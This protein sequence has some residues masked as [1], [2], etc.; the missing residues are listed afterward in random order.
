MIDPV[1]TRARRAGWSGVCTTEQGE[2]RFAFFGTCSDRCPT[3]HRAEIKAILEV[4]RRARFPLKLYT[5][6]QSAVKAWERGREYCCDSSRAAADIWREIWV[7]YDRL[8]EAMDEALPVLAFQL[9]WVKSH[10]GEEALRE[11]VMDPRVQKL[12]ALADHYAGEGSRWARELVPNEEQLDVYGT[13]SAFYRV[14]GA[15]CSEWPADYVQDRAKPEPGPA[16]GG[17]KEWSVHPSR[18]HEPWRALGGQGLCARCGRRSQVS[19]GAGLADFFRS[20]CRMGLQTEMASL[21]AASRA[22]LLA[23]REE[24][25]SSGA[26]PS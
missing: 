17:V 7:I 18:P 23:R 4:V 9:I 2:L 22:S 5:D 1:P 12:N 26:A 21:T 8:L 13:A 20:P 14:M 25:T 10:T 11:G 24:M 15:L 6:H 3:A 16:R 19:C